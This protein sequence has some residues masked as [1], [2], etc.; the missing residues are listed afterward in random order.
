[1]LRWRHARRT[2][3]GHFVAGQVVG[4]NDVAWSESGSEALSDPGQES[5]AVD[6]TVEHHRGDDAVMAQGGDQG[7]GIPVTEGGSTNHARAA[8]AAA[9]KARHV[10]LGPGLIEKDQ[11]MRIQP[12]LQFAPGTARLG[13]VCT[14]LLGGSERLFLR[15][16]PSKRTVFHTVAMLALTP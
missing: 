2:H 8:W 7:A 5:A 12:G 15:V 4:D 14:R 16:R 3:A 13:D 6:G 1:M 9:I 10:G 11:P